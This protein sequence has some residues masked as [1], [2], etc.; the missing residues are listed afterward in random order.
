M[1]STPTE[2]SMFCCTLFSTFRGVDILKKIRTQKLASR[3]HSIVSV[4]WLIDDLFK[5][6]GV[7]KT[8][9][10]SVRIRKEVLQN[11][12][13][14]IHLSIKITNYGNSR[15]LFSLKTLNIGKLKIICLCFFNDAMDEF[16][17]NFMVLTDQVIIDKM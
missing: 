13:V 12:N 9:V 5:L 10:L 14:N 2:D 3:C 17:W 11:L 4:V 6:I 1:V 8:T 16:V 15:L 7:Y